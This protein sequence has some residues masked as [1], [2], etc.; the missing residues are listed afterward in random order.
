M[1]STHLCIC[2]INHFSLYARKWSSLLCHTFSIFVSM[3]CWFPHDVFLHRSCVLFITDIEKC[4]GAQLGLKVAPFIIRQTLLC[5]FIVY[6]CGQPQFRLYILHPSQ[7]KSNYDL[8]ILNF[9]QNRIIKLTMFTGFQQALLCSSGRGARPR[10]PPNFTR[11]PS[12]RYIR[13]ASYTSLHDSKN[14]LNLSFTYMLRVCFVCPFERAK[15]GNSPF[16]KDGSN[17]S[18]I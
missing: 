17:I 2:F 7:K 1:G 18:S 15:L 12:R 14:I 8:L 5:G 9:L 4:F 11:T 16:I 13:H 3:T 6:L 10:P